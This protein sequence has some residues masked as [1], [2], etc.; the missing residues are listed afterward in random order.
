MAG[1]YE[2]SN[3]GTDFVKRGNFFFFLL[4]YQCVV[5]RGCQFLAV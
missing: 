3:E 5:E 4:N 2:G 1:S